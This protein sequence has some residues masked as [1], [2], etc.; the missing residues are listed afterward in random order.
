M[1]SSPRLPRSAGGWEEIKDLGHARLEWL[2]RYFP[3]TNGIPRHDTIARVHSRLEPKALQ[4]SF[5]S[6]VQAAS[7]LRRQVKFNMNGDRKSALHM[8]AR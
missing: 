6:W 2:R 7:E 1:K 5:M 3:Y 8:A 4:E